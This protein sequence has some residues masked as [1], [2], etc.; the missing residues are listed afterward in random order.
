VRQGTDISRHTPN[1]FIQYVADNVDHNIRSIDGK[2]T[3]HGMGMIA[4][5]TPGHDISHHVPRVIVTS[6]DIAAIGRV[7][8]EPFMGVCDGLRSMKYCRLPIIK[9]EDKTSGT[10]SLW[11]AYLSLCTKRP[12]WSGFMQMVQQGTHPGKS[13]VLFLPMID[14]NPSDYTCINSTL[15][16]ICEHASR[17]SVTPIVP[18][19]QPLWW[20]AREIIESVQ[21]AS[22]L[23][24]I[25]L[26]LGG[27]HTEMSFLGCIGHIM[28]GSGLREALQLIYAKGAVDHMLSG[29]Q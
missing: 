10:D 2:N 8:I 5:I 18:F 1:Q 4:T 21:E 3:F 14:M 16:F 7:N 19:D 29:K 27:F 20:K 23:C 11:K 17:Y 25:V 12:S 26:R 15:H 22:I 24:H 13:S 6:E 28:A 9:I